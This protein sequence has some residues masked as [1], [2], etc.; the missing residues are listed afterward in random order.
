MIMDLSPVFGSLGL[1]KFTGTI[2]RFNQGSRS[3]GKWQETYD[4][5]EAVDFFTVP[6]DNDV[7]KPDPDAGGEIVVDRDFWFIGSDFDIKIK[8]R[9]TYNSQTFIIREIDPRPHGVFTFAKG[10]FRQKIDV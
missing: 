10:F 8:D 4:A 9:L 7:K 5:P 6:S 3:G 1:G 2:E